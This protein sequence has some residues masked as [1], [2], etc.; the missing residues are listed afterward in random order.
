MEIVMKTQGFLLTALLVFLTSSTPAQV[1]WQ[2]DNG[3]YYANIEDFAV[4]VRNGE[5][6][7]YA[8]DSVAG[9]SSPSALVLKSTN[10]RSI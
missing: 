5:V 10:R 2:F 8:A 7:L 4:G 3:P 6:V 1:S 9:E